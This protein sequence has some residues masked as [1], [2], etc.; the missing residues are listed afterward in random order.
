M[1]IK[2]LSNIIGGIGMSMFLISSLIKSKKNILC[3]QNVGHVIGIIAEALSMTYSSIVQEIISIIRNVIT[4][5]GKNSNVVNIVLVVLGTIVGIIINIVIDGNLWYGYLPVLG[6]AEYTFCIV[7]D[8]L[9]NERNLKLSLATSNF[10]WAIYFILCGLYVSGIFNAV[11]GC[12]SIYS[13]LT[14]NKSTQ[15]ELVTE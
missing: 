9:V 1:N 14:Y 2:I 12:T 6:N 10:L 11:V 4:L 13:Y 8:K 5:K 7:N 3:I 15:V